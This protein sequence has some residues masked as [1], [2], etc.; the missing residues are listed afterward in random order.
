M[1]ERNIGSFTI[2]ADYIRDE[3]EKV[4]KVF[5][6]IKCVP[7]RAE[8]LFVNHC[9]QYIAL[10]EPFPEIPDGCKIPQYTLVIENDSTGWPCCITVEDAE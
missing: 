2:P 6:I 1:N 5:S 10:A 3:P 9:M 8:C 4:A 7:I